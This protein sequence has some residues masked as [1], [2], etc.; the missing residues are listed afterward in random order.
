MLRLSVLI[1]MGAAVPVA[2]QPDVKPILAK[3]ILESG[4]TLKDLQ[5]FIEPRLPVLPKVKSKDE[6]EKIAA[7]LRE[8]MFAKV[9]FRGEAAKWRVAKNKIDESFAAIDGG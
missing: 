5:A 1:L 8:D 9:V 7:R 4:Q 2:A 3:P 6:W